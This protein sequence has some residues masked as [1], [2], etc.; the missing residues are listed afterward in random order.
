[1]SREDLSLVV[2]GI[3]F[4]AIGAYLVSVWALIAR[5][6]TARPD[7]YQ[8]LGK[9][10]GLFSP[11]APGTWQLMLFV[12]TGFPEPSARRVRF[13][14]WTT[15]VLLALSLWLLFNRGKALLAIQR[16]TL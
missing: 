11:L 9:P 14:V 5:L 2:G 8:Q 10:T 4:V 16:F 6:Q 13:A 12:L 7:L 1:M 15:R 3:L